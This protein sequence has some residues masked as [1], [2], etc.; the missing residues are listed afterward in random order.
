MEA[1]SPALDSATICGR[2]RAIVVFVT[3]PQASHVWCSRISSST[4][5][6]PDSPRPPRR[7]AAATL[8]RSPTAAAAPSCRS[9]GPPRRSPRAAPGRLGHVDRAGPRLLGDVEVLRGADHQAGA[10]DEH[11]PQRQRLH[12]R[13]LAVLAG[14][15]HQHGA[16][17]ERAGVVQFE[18]VDEQPPLPRQ[19]V[20]AEHV[21]RE[22]D[23]AEPG[24][25][26]RRQ[27]PARRRPQPRGLVADQ[28]A[29]KRCDAHA[30]PAARPVGPSPASRRRGPL[31][32]A[33]VPPRFF[34]ATVK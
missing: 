34:S 26:V 14:D 27:R 17:P 23:S 20:D 9:C 30:Q 13:R 25:G 24:R 19:Q 8:Y 18:R 4:T 33:G 10:V 28:A 6:S 1:L 21:L 32:S 2:G 12:P 31:R 15:H 22:V 16:E 3:A 7:L 29:R 5:R 11:P